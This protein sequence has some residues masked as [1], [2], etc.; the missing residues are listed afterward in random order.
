MGIKTLVLVINYNHFR[1]NKF[2]VMKTDCIELI[3]HQHILNYISN[4]MKCEDIKVSD[5]R[6]D[7]VPLIDRKCTIQQAIQ[8]M[9]KNVHLSDHH[10]L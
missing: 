7:R 5:I 6:G 4:N 9:E 3:T 8:L 2:L 10:N 1:V